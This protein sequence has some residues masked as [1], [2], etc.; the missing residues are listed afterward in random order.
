MA[1][2][3]CEKDVK[4]R[5]T[6]GFKQNSSINNMINDIDKIKHQLEDLKVKFQTSNF[7]WH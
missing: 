5:N 3:L 1:L 2:L 7:E 4:C 6:P